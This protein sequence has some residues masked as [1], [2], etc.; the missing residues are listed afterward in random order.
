L[1]LVLSGATVVQI[2]RQRLA[3][4]GHHG[5]ALAASVASSGE[6][7]AGTTGSTSADVAL[8][9]GTSFD[10]RITVG[11]DGKLSLVLI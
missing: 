2:S 10:V 6:A 3:D 9:P 4:H 11:E 5:P 8:S 7:E 1:P